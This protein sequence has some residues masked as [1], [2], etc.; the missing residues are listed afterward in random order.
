MLSGFR[1]QRAVSALD[2]AHRFGLER[3]PSAP[4]MPGFPLA[5]RSTSHRH[6]A[7]AVRM[8]GAPAPALMLELAAD[9]D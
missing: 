7:G 5:R 2:T 6:G 4:I 8:N 3:P 9:E 1:K